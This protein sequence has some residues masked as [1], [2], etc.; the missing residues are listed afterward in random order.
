MKAPK[1]IIKINGQDL[2]M[3]CPIANKAIT[4]LVFEEAFFKTSHVD[5]TFDDAVGFDL[6]PEYIH[7]LD[8][9]V[10][11][12]YMG[13]HQ[14]LTK[15]FEGNIVET[16]PSGDQ[17]ENPRL[18]VKAYDYSWRMKIP[19]EPAT[20]TNTNLYRIITELVYNAELVPLIRPEKALKEVTADERINSI[21]QINLTDWEILVKAAELVNYKL[22]VRND[23][24]YMVSDQWLRNE[25][26]DADF[27]RTFIYNPDEGET[28][29]ETTF[30]LIAVN[31]RIAREGQRLKVEVLSWS[32]VARDGT[33]FGDKTLGDLQDEDIAYTEM[34]VRSTVTE[35]LRINKLVKDSNA[36]KREA[37]AEL[38]KRADYL[39]RGDAIIEGDPD[40]HIGMRANFKMKIFGNIG[41]KFSGEYGIEGVRQSLNDNGFITEMDL[42]R[43]MLTA[44]ISK[45]ADFRP[46]VSNNE[47]R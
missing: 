9:P 13:Y 39:V 29:G 1:Y 15:V 40:V 24:V 46:G 16:N 30:P 31:P 41:R 28:D 6:K 7:P 42:H 32:P 17:G 2:A 33:K 4:R 19:R 10:L 20:Y 5:L 23:N 3:E 18:V 26:L 27:R 47:D 34:V 45:S 44:D 36:A 35:T 14:N 22:F 11:K 8:N 12:L 37:E 25:M 38:R 21:T 43:N